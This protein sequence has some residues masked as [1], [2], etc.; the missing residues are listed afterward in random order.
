MSDIQRKDVAGY[1]GLYYVTDAGQ[2]FSYTREVYNPATGKTYIRTGCELSQETTKNGYKRV[3][4]SKDGKA[5]K[6][7]VHRLVAKAFVLNP[8]GK[9]QVNHK[10]GDKTNNFAWNLEWATASENTQHAFDTGLVV[11]EKLWDDAFKEM[12]LAEYIFGSRLH[13]L[14]A[15]A[16]KYGV[17]KSTIHNIVR[18]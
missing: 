4:V 9:S 3:I 12:V 6:L 8:E 14:V 5:R 16:K 1:E 7:S 2:V 13:G 15:L 11:A 17:S 18:S 10:D